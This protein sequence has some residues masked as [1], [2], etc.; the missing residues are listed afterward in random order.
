MALMHCPH[1][2]RVMARGLDKHVAFCKLDKTDDPA[3][4]ADLTRVVK[5][6]LG[7]I[8]AQDKVIATLKRSKRGAGALPPGAPAPILTETDLKLVFAEGVQ[9][10]LSLHTWPVAVVDRTPYIFDTVWVEATDIQLRTLVSA[11][12]QQLTT[13]FDAYVDRKGWRQ[14]DPNG[15][16]P[17]YAGKLYA[18]DP[19]SLQKALLK[20]VTV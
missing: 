8:D 11:I 16:Y 3:S 4:L 1:C 13:L 17:E 9:A 19:T 10:L 20:T 18:I 14:N 2:L 6:L 15:R 7:R 5:H 12:M